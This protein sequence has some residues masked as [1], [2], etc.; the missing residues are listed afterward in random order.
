MTDL[1]FQLVGREVLYL[2]SPNLIT[3]IFSSNAF[4]LIVFSTTALVF[5]K[6][7]L[8]QAHMVVLADKFRYDQLWTSIMAIRSQR[9][10][11][12]LLAKLVTQ[13]QNTLHSTSSLPVLARQ[14][15][16]CREYSFSMRAL[17][18]LKSN[19]SM[20]SSKQ[21]T[22][23]ARSNSAASISGNT[24]AERW[25]ILLD[26]GTPGTLDVQ[27]P[28]RSLDQLYF[29]AIAL[30]PILVDKIKLWALACGGCF[31]LTHKA[32]VKT[33]VL[34]S[35]VEAA[36][37]E[38]H[39]QASSLE[40]VEDFSSLSADLCSVVRDTVL[41][42]GED[43]PLPPGYVRWKDARAEELQSGN[44]IKWGSIKSVQRALEKS[45]R[46]YNKV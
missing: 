22:N 38:G 15:N 34:N 10:Q 23:Q 39:V 11:V 29:Q 14:L 31:C 24:P 18:L 36:S 32:K 42:T 45:T 7:A 12:E 19:D 6:R 28:V 37:E 21:C 44:I 9:D 17:N 30:N 5:H 27:R 43:T 20:Q 26:C 3:L 2:Q 13:I 8:Y 1:F 46:S 41:E 4:A 16:R 25:K 35:D 33:S 40:A